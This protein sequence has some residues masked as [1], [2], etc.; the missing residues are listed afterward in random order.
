MSNVFE[1][2]INGVEV[3]SHWFKSGRVP[4]IKRDRVNQPLPASFDTAINV[5]TDITPEKGDPI[6]IKEDGVI[7]FSGYIDRINK[8]ESQEFYGLEIVSALMKLKAVTIDYD[9]LHTLLITG[10]TQNEYKATDNQGF[11]N[12]AMIWLFKK[13]FEEAGLVLDTTEVEDLIVESGATFGTVREKNL[14]LDENA[15]FAA[16]QNSALNHILID[17]QIGQGETEFESSKINGLQLFQRYCIGRRWYVQ[18][19]D[20]A[21][22]YKIFSG[23]GEDWE[24]DN[25]NINESLEFSFEDQEQD[26]LTGSDL[27][28]QLKYSSSAVG[29]AVTTIRQLYDKVDFLPADITV[30]D[31]TFNIVA[32]GLQSG[33][34]MKFTTTGTLPSGLSTTATYYLIDVED[35]VFKVSLEPDGTSVAISSQGTGTHSY[36]GQYELEVFEKQGFGKFEV[37]YFNNLRI[38]YHVSGTTTGQVQ[39]NAPQTVIKLGDGYLNFYHIDPIPYQQILTNPLDFSK[40]R[41]LEHWINIKEESHLIKQTTV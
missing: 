1:F 27:L 36:Y 12:V 29:G 22:G 3:T 20:V 4:H 28:L 17:A 33:S 40:P 2:Y 21:N 23:L 5:N 30:V 16:N 6:I 31:N 32:H 25:Y 13:I 39:T 24:T 26:Q 38:M 15:L 34:V 35:D 8:L 18:P 9:T 14:V 37:P 41:M 10:A 7:R 11:P 19:D